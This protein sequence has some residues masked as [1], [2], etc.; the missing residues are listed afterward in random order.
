VKET[1]RD[2]QTDRGGE[3]GEGGRLK[4]TLMKRIRR[5]QLAFLGH[6]LRRRCMGLKIW[7]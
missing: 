7:W 1:E 4:P 5:R 3:K 6:V 2:R